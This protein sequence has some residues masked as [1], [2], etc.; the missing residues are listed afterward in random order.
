MKD[1]SNNICI[2]DFRK[3]LYPATEE[4][5]NISGFRTPEDLLDIPFIGLYWVRGFSKRIVGNT[6]FALAAYCSVPETCDLDSVR[7]CL[8][9]V[10]E[11]DN[12]IAKKVMS[13]NAYDRMKYGLVDKMLSLAGYTEEMTARMTFRQMVEL[14]YISMDFLLQL[15]DTVWLAYISRYCES[16][17]AALSI[18]AEGLEVVVSLLRSAKELYE[19]ADSEDWALRQT[20]EDYHIDLDAP[21]TP[22]ICARSM[23][24]ALTDYLLCDELDEPTIIKLL[25]NDPESQNETMIQFAGRT[26]FLK[27]KDVLFATRRREKDDE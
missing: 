20:L 15:A 24:A 21:P 5:L 25:C 13:E 6:L 27:N 17:S 23:H 18:S 3:C 4:R 2:C 10:P 19:D 16:K 9:D 12:N 1:K 8:Q 22:D 26:D 11:M 14:K 7:A